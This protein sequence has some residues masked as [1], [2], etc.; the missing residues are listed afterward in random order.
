MTAGERIVSTAA[1]CGVECAHMAWPEGSAPELPWAVWRL[2]S[3]TGF[4]ADDGKYAGAG[5]YAVELYERACDEGLHARIEKVVMTT[6][7][8]RIIG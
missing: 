6:W 3:E 7:Q 5:T 4:F 8:F 2:D 1:S